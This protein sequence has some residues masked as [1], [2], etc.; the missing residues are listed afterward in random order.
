MSEQIWNEVDRYFE[1]SLL[2]RDEALEH[3]LATSA[4]AG[5]P[6]IPV[7]PT[8]G[9]MLHLFARMVRARRVLEIGT[10]G[11]YSAIWLARALPADGELVS[12]EIDPTRA[13]LAR[14]NLAHAALDGIAQVRVGAALDTLPSVRGP[15]D[16]VFID[17]D[18]PNNAN[19]FRAAV[20]L[21][22]PGGVIVVDNVG[23]AGAVVDAAST[24]ESV[25][26]VRELMTTIAADPR[27][28]ATAIQ[29]VGSKGHDGFVLAMKK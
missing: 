11:G 4:A 22:R 12:L 9:K 27:V 15:F 6:A 26:G 18:K 13:E 23:R 17:A 25:R 1:D 10:L 8:Q 24:D 16:L 2:D 5:L 21:L 3:A 19:Y 7:S 28:T 20:D 29:T 14:K